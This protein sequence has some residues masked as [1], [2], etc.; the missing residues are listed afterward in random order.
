MKFSVVSLQF[1]ANPRRFSAQSGRELRR[2][3]V[4]IQERGKVSDN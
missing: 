1:S 4:S 3:L 2:K